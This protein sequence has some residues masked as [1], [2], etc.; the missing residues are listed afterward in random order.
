MRRQSCCGTKPSVTLVLPASH[1]QVAFRLRKL[2][3]E[4][5]TGRSGIDPLV[6]VDIVKTCSSMMV[7]EGG[8]A[9]QALRAPSLGIMAI[10]VDWLLLQLPMR[11]ASSI[12][13]PVNAF[14]VHVRSS[15]D[16]VGPPLLTRP[17]YLNAR[18]T[19]G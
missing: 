9:R 4:G 11:V 3:Q 13:Q 19:A 7:Q 12:P 15:A 10:A 18:H 1:E 6:T 14:Q 8:S 2:P 16:F 17:H 5:Y